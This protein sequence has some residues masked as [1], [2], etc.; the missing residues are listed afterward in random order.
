MQ[1][2]SQSTGIVRFLRRQAKIHSPHRI[3]P[4]NACWMLNSSRSWPGGGST[5]SQ[6]DHTLSFANP[7]ND[8]KALNQGSAD[9][10]GDYSEVI[11]IQGSGFETR[12]LQ[13]PRT[14]SLKRHQRTFPS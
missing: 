13:R 5:G 9:L 8:F 4:D 2:G 7:A 14:F 10:G 11:T 3:T 6:G 1:P 12:Q